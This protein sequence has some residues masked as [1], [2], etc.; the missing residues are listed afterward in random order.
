MATGT[1]RRD[2]VIAISK[3]GEHLLRQRLGNIA[4]AGVVAGLTAAGLVRRDD[5]F[6]A[7]VLQKLASGKADVRANGTY[8]NREYRETCHPG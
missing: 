1:R 2:N 3:F 7:C 6:T 5:H 4:R 8:L